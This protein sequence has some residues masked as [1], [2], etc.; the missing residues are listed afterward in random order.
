MA[1][2]MLLIASLAWLALL[3]AAASGA[4]EALAAAVIR[5]SSFICH[6]QPDRSFHWGAAPWAVCARC[7][8]LYAGAP[9]GALCAMT[10]QVPLAR[11]G[12]F[13]LLC[14]TAMP[15]GASWLLEHGAGWSVTNETRFAAAVPLGAAV[16]W[17]IARTLAGTNREYS[18]GMN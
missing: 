17:I 15:T 6:Q 5:F 18:T 7:L 9:L 13:L 1:A 4:F 10:V 16:V 3:A 2:S 14:M 12:N 11:A 8:G